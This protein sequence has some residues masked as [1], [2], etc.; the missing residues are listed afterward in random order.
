M[1]LDASLHIVGYPCGHY[2][3]IL[4]AP[5][6]GLGIYVVILLF[7]LTQPA[8]VL[9]HPEV[10]HGLLIDTGVMLVHS[11]LEIYFGLD[12]MVQT[13]GIPG[14]LGAGLLA[15]QDVIR[16]ACDLLH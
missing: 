2:E 11:R 8:L 7:V 14:G 16:T 9:E 6:H 15:V 1:L 4:S 3:S 12:D 10:L 5:V 13:H